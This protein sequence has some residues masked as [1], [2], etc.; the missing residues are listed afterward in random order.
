MKPKY[1]KHTV[2]EAVQLLDVYASQD[3]W[4]GD[5]EHESIL[6]TAMLLGIE[7][8]DLDTPIGDATNL[9]C[10]AWA[11][12][13]GDIYETAAEAAQRLREGWRP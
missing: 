1:S 7:S 8:V 5:G 11:E 9:A 10:A 3:F 12:L 6:G 4:A 2:D 13:P